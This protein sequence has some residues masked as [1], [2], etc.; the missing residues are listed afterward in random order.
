MMQPVLRRILSIAIG[1]G[2]VAILLSQCRKPAWWLGRLIARNMN[3]RHA[4]LTNWGLSHVRL[5]P[6]FT[7]LDVGCG[8]GR[9]IDTLATVATGGK[10]YGIDYSP[11]SVDTA[12]RTNAAWIEKGRV[13]LRQCSVSTLPFP[14]D[15]FD[16][17][18]A[19]ETHYY[20][21]NL[22]ADLREILRVLKP[23]G[24]LVI[25]AETYRGRRMDWLYRPAMRLLRA[26]YLS[27]DEH[28]AV[29]ERAG[30]SQVEVFTEGARGWICALGRKP[31]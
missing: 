27:V 28:R 24:A 25:I 9:T 20:W 23:G 17:V 5:E 3:V 14:A 30:F 22:D 18:T 16:V 1:G 6:T 31:Q 13:D 21:P 11:A 2:A 4:R 19:V 26:T 15:T 8:G 12:R 7:M 10:V 29:F